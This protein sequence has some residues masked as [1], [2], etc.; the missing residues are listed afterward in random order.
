MQVGLVL[1][2]WRGVE[3]LRTKQGTSWGKRAR[4]SLLARIALFLLPS[5][6][7]DYEG[8]RHLVREWLIEFDEQGHPW[9]EIGLDA[10]GKPLLAGPDRRNY[11]FWLDTNMRIADFHGES[12]TAEEFE[13]LWQA[14]GPRG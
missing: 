2:A 6:N 5:A 8:K 12:I 1:V 7:P 10:D 3:Y 11:G 4:P 9:R 13:R 14:A